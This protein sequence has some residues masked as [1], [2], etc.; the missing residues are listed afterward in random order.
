MLITAN[1]M[2]RLTV[3][4]LLLVVMGSTEPAS[5]D[6]TRK[7]WRLEVGNQ[8]LYESNIYHSFADSSE[9]N[10]FLNS[11]QVVLSIRLGRTTPFRQLIQ[12]YTELDLY[13]S[14]SSR[15][16]SAFGVKY[17]PTWRY[18]PRGSLQLG[19]ELARRK[20]DLVDDDGQVQAR[21]LEKWQSDLSVMNNYSFGLIR[22]QIGAGYSDDNYDE[23]DTTAVVV[24][25][26]TTVSLISYDYHA[27]TWLARIGVHVTPRLEIYGKHLGE[28][29][30]Y[31]ERR[32]YTVQY[33]AFKGR[34]FEIREFRENTFEAGLNYEFS[35]HNE[36]GIEADF[37]R[38]RD[39]F[40]NFYGFDQ[41]QYRATVRLHPGARHRTTVTFRFKNK[42]YDNYWN[43]RIGR[44][45]RVWIDY[46]DFQVDYDYRLS[47]IVTLT[48]YVRDFNKVSNDQTYDYQDFTAG[49]GIRVE[50]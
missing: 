21:T 32:T 27:Y 48:A 41:W 22:T 39:N 19:G 14:Y 4:G 30:N 47:N 28:K 12:G 42:D 3:F 45:N 13:P 17:E 49:T 33:G 50:L 38:R 46:A 8:A 9:T 5:A 29:R 26:P 11:M 24:G 10:A 44:L 6:T 34:P 25:T 16:K 43:S 37:V 35:G 1:T 20:K 31:D 7:A 2:K 40:E 18:S 15:N 36:I 23:R